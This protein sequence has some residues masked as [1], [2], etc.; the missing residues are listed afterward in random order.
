ML[1]RNGEEYVDEFFIYVENGKYYYIYDRDIREYKLENGI[2]N[3]YNVK[4]SFY[5]LVDKF[6]L[7]GILF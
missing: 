2:L 3:D 7:V 6:I 4:E 1:E 5:Y